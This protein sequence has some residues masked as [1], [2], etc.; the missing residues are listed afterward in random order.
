M[1][2]TDMKFRVG[3]S[4]NTGAPV[5]KLPWLPSRVAP[6]LGYQNV[7]QG[8]LSQPLRGSARQRALMYI[9]LKAAK[10]EPGGCDQG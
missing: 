4:G 6:R 1:R 7:R 2:H 10:E 3:M 9:D 8:A 5:I